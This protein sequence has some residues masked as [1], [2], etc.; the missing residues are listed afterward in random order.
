MWWWFWSYG[1]MHITVLAPPSLVNIHDKE[2]WIKLGSI[3]MVTAFGQAV[4]L[5]IMRSVPNSS[6]VKEIRQ[7]YLVM[8][9]N[10]CQPLLQDTMSVSLS[11]EHRAQIV[12]DSCTPLL[13]RFTSFSRETMIYSSDIIIIWECHL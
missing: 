1:D 4:C 5:C 2:Q 7:S 9:I 3:A 8:W 6:L 11:L 13:E 10:E 12:F